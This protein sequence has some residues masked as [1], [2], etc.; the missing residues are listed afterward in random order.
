MIMDELDKLLKEKK[1]RLNTL[2]TDYNKNH[3]RTLTEHTNL[4]IKI[5]KLDIEALLIEIRQLEKLTE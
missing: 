4:L 3:P 2:E 5:A 1:D